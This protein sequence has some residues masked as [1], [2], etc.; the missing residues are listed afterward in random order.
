VVPF[1]RAVLR[2][3]G[4]LNNFCVTLEPAEQRDGGGARKRAPNAAGKPC[5]DQPGSLRSPA[6]VSARGRAR[7]E[8]LFGARVLKRNAHAHRPAGPLDVDAPKTGPGM[9][10]GQKLKRQRH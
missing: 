9:G 4:G 2:G 8:V 1:A 5:A 10:D 3:G 6:R 7:F